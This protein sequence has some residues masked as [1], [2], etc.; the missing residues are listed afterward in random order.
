MGDECI[1]WKVDGQCDTNAE[2]MRVN[3]PASCGGCAMEAQNVVVETET[4]GEELVVEK[5]EEEVRFWGVL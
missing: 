1:G 4:N 2:F 3:C 5:E